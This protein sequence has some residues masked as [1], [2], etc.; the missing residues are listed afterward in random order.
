MY[1]IRE[2]SNKINFLKNKQ[3]TNTNTQT[4]KESK[5]Q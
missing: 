1:C 3:N 4:D 5:G 2:T